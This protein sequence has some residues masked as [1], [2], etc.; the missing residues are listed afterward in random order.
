M[1]SAQGRFPHNPKVEGS[2]PSADF[3]GPVVCVLDGDTI[4]VLH[5]SKAERIRL[6]GIDCPEKGQAF[7]KRAKQ[8]ASD[9]TIGKE[10]RLHIG[11]PRSKTIRKEN[12]SGTAVASSISGKRLVFGQLSRGVIFDGMWVTYT[13][14]GA[15]SN[16]SW[17]FGLPCVDGPPF[18]QRDKWVFSISYLGGGLPVFRCS[19]ENRAHK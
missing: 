3:T 11:S 1:L 8:A 2:N 16:P 4:E 18:K 17:P 5:N 6:S 14:K 13:G 7:G 19:G 12:F 15:S 9:L 10:V